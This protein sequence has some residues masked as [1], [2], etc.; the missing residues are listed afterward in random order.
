M[1]FIGLI[2]LCLGAILARY[3]RVFAL[4]PAMIITT[5][6]VAAVEWVCGYYLVQ[7][8]LAS[9]E[10]VCALQFGYLLGLS[11]KRFGTGPRAFRAAAPG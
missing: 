6:A 7:A 10:A 5:A 11:V 8:L 9:G 4:I 3:F 1:V 2:G